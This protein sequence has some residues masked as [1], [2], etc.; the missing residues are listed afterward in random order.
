MKALV[1]GP[2]RPGFNFWLHFWLCGLGQR[3]E[4]LGAS[5]IVPIES[6]S[7]HSSVRCVLSLQDLCLS[8]PVLC[9]S[10][11]PPGEDPKLR[12]QSPSRLG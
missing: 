5:V 3:T 12:Q 6:F 2:G 11:P 7:K 9:V 1:L 8:A 4:F 10:P